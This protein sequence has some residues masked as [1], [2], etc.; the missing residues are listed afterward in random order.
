MNYNNRK[1]TILTAAEADSID[2]SKVMETSADTLHWNNDKTKTWVKYEGDQPAFLSGKPELMHW[3]MLTET[4]K[5]EWC[6][7]PPE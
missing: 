1:Y 3:Q 2:F 5:A 6:P 7:E 4:M